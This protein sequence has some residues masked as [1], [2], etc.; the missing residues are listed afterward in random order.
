MS[1]MV[2]DLSFGIAY[3]GLH[4]P[5]VVVLSALAIAEDTRCVSLGYAAD[6]GSEL[7][8]VVGEQEIAAVGS[9]SFQCVYG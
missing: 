8:G 7:C 2:V 5:D 1:G 3:N 9:E 6:A 4:A